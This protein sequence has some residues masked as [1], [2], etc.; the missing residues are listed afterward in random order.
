MVERQGNKHLIGE[1]DKN[2]N[3]FGFNVPNRNIHK[4][5]RCLEEDTVVI[6]KGMER[7]EDLP[8]DDV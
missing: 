8:E 1:I 4:G 3:T 7:Q 6:A 2:H 5:Q